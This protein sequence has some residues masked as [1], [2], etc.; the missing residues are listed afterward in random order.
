MSSHLIHVGDY[1]ISETDGRRVIPDQHG[2]F[3]GGIDDTYDNYR[4]TGRRSQNT[5]RC[6]ASLYEVSK[7][8]EL[9][10]ILAETGLELQGMTFTEHQVVAAVEEHH[11]SLE[12]DTNAVFFI[13]KRGRSD[14][15]LHQVR[16]FWYRL[17][18]QYG[19]RIGGPRISVSDYH[20]QKVQC[21][22][23]FNMRL[24][25]PQSCLLS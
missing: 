16:N 24:M 18:D 12:L 6:S 22:E 19:P 2:V 10:E 11:A 17:H 14:Y 25:L 1:V 15:Y 4:G 3:T 20:G 8:K 21:E 9:Q 7:H 23:R 13:V 5:P